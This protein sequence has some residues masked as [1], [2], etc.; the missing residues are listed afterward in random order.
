MAKRISRRELKEK[1]RNLKIDLDIALSRKEEAIDRLEELQKRF[2]EM[3]SRVETYDVQGGAIECIEIKP[4]TWG[5][6]EAFCGHQEFSKE[7]LD[8]IKRRLVSSLADGMMKWNLVQIIAHDGLTPISP[9]TVGAKLYVVPW[10]KMV[11]K[12]FVKP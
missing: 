11:K 10:D 9:A 5:T 12:I 1:I 7:Q 6:Y 8:E 2:D 4:Q 3:G